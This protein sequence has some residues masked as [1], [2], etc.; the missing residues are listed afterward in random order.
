MNYLIEIKLFYDW[1]ETHPMSAATISL[2]HAL[3]AIANRSGWKKTLNVPN[4][5]LEARSGLS[6]TTICRERER[7]RKVG[8]IT[9]CTHKRSQCTTYSL[10]PLD[11][12]S[13]S[14][15]ETQLAPHSEAQSDVDDNAVLQ[16]AFQ[17]FQIYKLNR[18]IIK[19]KTNKKEKSTT[20]GKEREKVARKRENQSNLTKS[21]FS[22]RSKN[23]GVS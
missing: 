13:E 5:L 6:C 1:L 2:W 12:P 21:N 11:P 9:F 10:I 18:F 22:L 20:I 17:N 15:F 7:L 19:E 8:R 4:V 3:M 14:Q 23:H 16:D